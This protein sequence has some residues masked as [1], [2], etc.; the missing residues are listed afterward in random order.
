VVHGHVVASFET[1][2][3]MMRE[4]IVH[5]SPCI[6]EIYVSHFPFKGV[7]AGNKRIESVFFAVAEVIIAVARSES[8]PA[9][10]EILRK[11]ESSRFGSHADPFPRHPFTARS[12]MQRCPSLAATGRATGRK[13]YISIRVL[14]LRWSGE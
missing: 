6:P 1:H 8:D 3:D 9:G 7:A 14:P 2:A 5:A 13:E 10:R 4:P 12:H 11:S